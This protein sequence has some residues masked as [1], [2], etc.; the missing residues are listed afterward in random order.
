[1][2]TVVKEQHRVLLWEQSDVDMS[3]SNSFSGDWE[4]GL[5]YGSLDQYSADKNL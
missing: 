3:C 1:M 2:E 4:L 5:Q